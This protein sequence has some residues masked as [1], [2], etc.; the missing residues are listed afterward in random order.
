MAFIP[1]PPP[2]PPMPEFLALSRE[3]S[4]EKLTSFDLLG[5]SQLIDA[6]NNH[7]IALLKVSLE[8]NFIC[9]QSNTNDLN[10]VCHWL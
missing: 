9:N 2:P 10:A 6:I 8:L 7:D 1:P 3:K 5:S 4:S